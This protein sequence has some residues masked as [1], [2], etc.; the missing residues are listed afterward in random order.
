M[1]YK[2]DIMDVYSITDLLYIHF[3][4]KPITNSSFSIKIIQSSRSS[5]NLKILH[6]GFAYINA[7]LLR[8]NWH[9]RWLFAP[10]L[11]K[12]IYLINL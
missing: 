4:H 3:S 8:L 5:S 6:H 2:V 12:E 1:Y 7:R 9:F 10:K 11:I